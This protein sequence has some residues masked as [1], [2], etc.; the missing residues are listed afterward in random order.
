MFSMSDIVK[1]MGPNSASCIEMADRLGTL[2]VG[3]LADILLLDGHPLE[4]YWNLLKTRVVLKS[5]KVVVDK[6]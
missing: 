2:E 1:L 5:G 6:R 4:G 3:K